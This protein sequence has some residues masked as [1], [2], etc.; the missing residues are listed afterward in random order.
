M[1]SSPSSALSDFAN[2]VTASSVD[3]LTVAGAAIPLAGQIFGVVTGAIGVFNFIQS[4]TNAD[5]NVLAQ[6]KILENLLQEDF[7]DTNVHIT[8]EALD[9]KRSDLDTA[10]ADAV[11]VFGKLADWVADSTLDADFRE[12]QLAKCFKATVIFTDPQSGAEGNWTLLWEDAP[13]YDDGWSTLPPPQADHVFH[14]T[15]SL[16]YFLRAIYIFVT[17]SVAWRPG[18]LNETDKTQ[19]GKC[20]DQLQIVH[21]TITAPGNTPTGLV[22]TRI[23]NVSPRASAG[24]DVLWVFGVGDPDEELQTS[25]YGDGGSAAVVPQS[26]L[27]PFGAVEEYSVANIVDSYWP[28]LPF[29]LDPRFTTIGDDFIALLRLR[30][31]DRRK[32]LYRRIGMPNLIQTINQLRTIA[33]QPTLTGK[34]WDTWSFKEALGILGLPLQRPVFGTLRTFLQPIPPYSGGVLYPQSAG[35]SFPPSP[36]PKSFRSLFMVPASVS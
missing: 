18:G 30:I 4:Q 34:P 27:W 13:K 20:A 14:Y 26:G 21:D 5:N 17:A 11:T 23:P 2:A 3:F 16:P 7:H 19:L 25:W 6:I 8:Q 12:E 29:R 1:S 36:L 10:L 33:G 35:Q 9:K 15:I 22:G 24:G 32:T 28:F 31:E